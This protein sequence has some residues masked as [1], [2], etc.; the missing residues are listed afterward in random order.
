LTEVLRKSGV[1]RDG[2]VADV[3]VESSRA[4][5]MSRIIRLRL[6]FEGAAGDTPHSLILKTALP[7]RLHARASARTSDAT[8][9]VSLIDTWSLTHVS[10]NDT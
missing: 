7:E 1:L 9:A 2:H 3:A 10:L 4:T 5:I 6:T 8:G